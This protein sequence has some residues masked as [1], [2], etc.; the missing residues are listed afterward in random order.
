MSKDDFLPVGTQIWF[1]SKWEC[2][3]VDSI[4]S[5]PGGQIIAYV[6]RKESGEKVAIDMQAATS[7]KEID[8]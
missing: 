8:P 6:V 2:G 5:G 1:P 4:L 7:S 3:T